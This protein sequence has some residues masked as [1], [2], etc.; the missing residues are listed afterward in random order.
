MNFIQF[1][2]S[3]EGFRNYQQPIMAG[4]TEGGEQYL[5]V[6]TGAPP[7]DLHRIKAGHVGFHR[8]QRFL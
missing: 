2:P 6:A 3:A 4:Q 5:T 7:I 1:E 8:A